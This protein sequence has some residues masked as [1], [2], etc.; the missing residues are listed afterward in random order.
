M[1]SKLTSGAEAISQPLF[2]SSSVQQMSLGATVHSDDGRIFRYV[3]A[4]GTALVPGKLQQAAAV[5][6]NHQN[7][8]V[9]AA[10]AVGATSVTV[11]LGATAATKDQYAGGT[12]VVSDAAGEGH[13]YLIKSHPA[14]I[15]G[16]SLTLTLE[17]PVVVALT[18]SSEAC[19]MP[20]IYNGVIVNPTTPT[21]VPV[22]V[23]IYPITASEFGFIQTR[24]P[25]SC[26]ND[27]GTAVGLGIA[28]S[29]AVAGAVKTQAATLHCL[30]SALQAGV[31][32]E[33]RTVFIGLD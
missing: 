25:V 11:T 10:A 31:D 29:Q 6:A 21:N 16:G 22:G 12:L 26:L 9:A 15:S 23:A 28:P 19:L 1:A 32:T 7:I 33:Y 2:S 17:D 18:T 20:N 24:G 8:A 30:G 27:S 14:A 3:K 5:V 13:T 4:G